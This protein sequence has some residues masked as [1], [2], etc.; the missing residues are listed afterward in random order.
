MEK[1][2]ESRVGRRFWAKAAAIVSIGLLTYLHATAFPGS[3]QFSE[4]K[5]ELCPI[6]DVVRPLSFE[7]DNSTVVKIISDP[8]FRNRSA[9]KLAGAVKIPTVTYDDSPPVEADPEYWRAKFEPFHE[10][11]ESTFPTL[12]DLFTVEKVNTWGLLLTWKGSDPSLKPVVLL[13]HQDVV[14]IQEATEHD[15]TYPPFEG[16]YDGDSLWG[17]GSADCKNLLIAHLEAAEELIASGFRPRRSIVYSFGFD[18]EIGGDYG[19]NHLSKVLIDRY[20]ADSVYA[21]LDEGGQSLI[22]LHDVQVALPGTGEK[23]SV[24]VYIS[25]NT[26][27]GHL[28][29]PPDHTSIGILSEVVT[30]LERHPFE[31][32]FTPQNPTFH[33][34]QCVAKHS[35]SLS[36]DIREALLDAEFDSRANRLARNYLAKES[37]LSRYLIGTSTAVDIIHGGV[38]SNA[39]PEYVQAVVNHR[40]AIESSVNATVSHDIDIVLGVART[41]GLGV[42]VNGEVILPPTENGHFAI[43]FDQ[44]LEPAPLTPVGDRHWNVLAGSLRHLYEEV[45][46]IGKKSSF[47]SPLVVAPGIATG[48]TDTRYYWDLTRHIY[49]YR[50]GIAQNV[51]IHAHGV[52]EHIPFDS[53]LQIVAFYYEYLQVI[54][55]ESD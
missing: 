36:S 9:A 15:W 1:Q 38:K 49:R 48:N 16:A 23:G 2:N 3:P 12:W 45:A 5:P 52:D 55:A 14:P 40:V 39:L 37:L 10:Y 51:L 42:T 32:V 20:G 47:T 34:Y 54:D 43:E 22:E 27:G 7:K 46:Q 30:L 31:S 6:Y 53:H 4:L 17:R 29:V 21:V 35:P 44:S 33:E 25:A 28:S 18:E 26:P 13:A 50:P 24:N 41:H 19:A 11:L 8:G